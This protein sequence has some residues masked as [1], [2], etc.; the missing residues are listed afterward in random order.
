MECNAQKD[1]VH[2]ILNLSFPLKMKTST[3]TGRKQQGQM[4]THTHYF[5]RGECKHANV[6]VCK[7]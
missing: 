6:C 5:G 4:E 1:K 2:D 7:M 3:Q